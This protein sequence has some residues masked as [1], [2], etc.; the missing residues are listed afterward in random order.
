MSEAEHQKCTS[1]LDDQTVYDWIKNVRFIDIP[2]KSP[3]GPQQ[4]ARLERPLLLFR[5][6]GSNIVAEKGADPDEG[7]VGGMGMG[8][9]VAQASEKNKGK[10]RAR[11]TFLDNDEVVGDL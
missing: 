9:G 6:V 8:V 11:V 2:N 4:M 1:I 5:N 3:P 10:K 7:L